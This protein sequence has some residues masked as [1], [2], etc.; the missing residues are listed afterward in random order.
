MTDPILSLQ[1][2]TKAFG[3]LTATNDVNLELPR[4]E[5]HA[6]IGPNGAGKSTLFALVAGQ[7]RPDSGRIILDGRDVTSVVGHRR[8]KLGV[9]RAFQVARVF[10][11]LTV[12]Q[13]IEAAL[14]V[15]TGRS[16]NFLS[17]TDNAAISE[18]VQTT[19]D[20]INM[21]ELG[22]ALA[23]DLSQGDRKCLEIGMALAL[24]PRL[25][26]LDEPTAGMSPE[27]TERTVNLVR[28]LW[29]EREM[30][31]LLTEHDMAVVFGLAQRVTVLHQGAVLAT[32]LPDEI[33][34]RSD[35]QDIYLGHGTAP[36]T[37]GPR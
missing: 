6:V 2:L 8:V 27:E 9:S 25:L 5:L 21:S 20:D 29:R 35:V 34:Q 30:T 31:V 28:R 17:R 32:G 33:R 11:E 12:R 23:S 16:R 13:N 18:G 15:H 10:G 14:L 36:P 7:L 37:G 24:E 1:R 19:L 22:P 26:L 4:G 3:G